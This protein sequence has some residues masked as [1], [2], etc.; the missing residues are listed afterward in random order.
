MHV[1]AEVEN[2]TLEPDILFRCSTQQYD[3]RESEQVRGGELLEHFD[4]VVHRVGPDEVVVEGPLIDGKRDAA[5]QG[6]DS[7][8]SKVIHRQEGLGREGIVSPSVGELHT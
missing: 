2:V 6:E 3:G 5:G 7:P 1:G 8:V 4:N